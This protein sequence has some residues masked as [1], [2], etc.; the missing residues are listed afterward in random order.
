M[1]PMFVLLFS[2]ACGHMHDCDCRDDFFVDDD[3]DGHGSLGES[4]TA[5]KAPPGYAP[6]SDDCDDGNAAIHPG[7]AESCNALD[8]DCDGAV[9]V[10]AADASIWYADADGDGYGDLDDR[11]GACA[12]PPG[13]VADATDCDDVSASIHPGAQETCNDL[14]D[15]CDGLLDDADPDVT[16][17][18]PFFLDADGDGYGVESAAVDACEQPAGYALGSGD[19]DDAAP[20]TFPGAQ[21]I[22]ANGVDDDC[23]TVVDGCSFAVEDADVFLTGTD[24]PYGY[25]GYRIET[26]DL[27][28]DGVADL[29]AGADFTADAQAYAAFGP[30]LSDL[31]TDD[32]DVAFRNELPRF[33]TPDS[34]VAG[35]ADGD[36]YD[37]VLF[38][39]HTDVHGYLFHGPVTADAGV[40][41]ADLELTGAQASMV[42]QILGDHDGDGAP[43]IAAR[44]QDYGIVRRGTVYVETGIATGTVDLAADATYSYNDWQGDEVGAA[45]VSLGDA[46]GDGID[47]LAIGDPSSDHRTVYVLAGGELPG[48]YSVHNAPIAELS[49]STGVDRFGSTIAA[50]DYDGDG[51]ADILVGTEMHPSVHGFLGPFAGLRESADADVRWFGEQ[52]LGYAIAA[53][54]DVDA[55]GQPDLLFGAPFANGVG[56]AYLQIG[57]ASG[58]VDAADLVSFHSSSAYF[59][60]GVAFVPD[61]TGDG[62][63]EVALGDIGFEPVA[64]QM[65]GRV[66]VFFSEAF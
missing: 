17:G 43:D 40:S 59:A 45:I 42:V 50:T 12:Q 47:D 31:T 51:Y 63:S 66:A 9:D 8:D 7:A 25:L 30:M 55:D 52:S 62:G 10:G 14:D 48:A 11:V 65:S 22:C 21:E 64:G 44:S 53:D 26:G 56:A 35:D 4:I 41:D 15:D 24:G 27:N 39:S 54:G 60:Y 19:C 61:W 46:T 16:G 49:S 3:G 34:M 58:V 28:A 23:D 18:D 36:G 32:A 6:T 1:R 29:I 33:I 57:A 37:D 2:A 20:T 38:S 5:C 13:T